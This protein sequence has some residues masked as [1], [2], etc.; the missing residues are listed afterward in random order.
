MRIRR[1]LAA[2]LPLVAALALGCATAPHGGDHAGHSSDAAA[3]RTDVIYS[4]GCGPEC[5][6]DT[7]SLKPGNC[8]CGKPMKWGHVVKVEGDEALLC[9]CNEGCKCA[10]DAGDPAKCGCGQPVKRV[11]LKGKGIYFCNC[12][13]ACKCNTISD[14]PAECGCGMQLKQ[15]N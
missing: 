4:C 15:A 13:G 11:S 6:C 1:I 10:I 14:K 12:G 3:A 9:T 7:V 5:K 8:A 2:A